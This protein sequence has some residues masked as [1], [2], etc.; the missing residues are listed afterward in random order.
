MSSNR[1]MVFLRAITV[2]SALG[3]ASMPQ[4]AGAQAASATTTTTTTTTTSDQDTA[5]QPLVLNPFIVDSSEDKGSYTANSTLA[6]TRVRTELKDVASAISVVTAQFLQD[7]GAKNQ[8][9]FLIYTPSTEV[10]GLRGNFSGVAGTAISEENTV[11]STTRVRG[12]DSADNTRDYFI[13]DI[14]WDAFDVGRVDLQRG[15]NSILFGTGSPAGIINV[16]TSG[17][18]FTNAYNVTNRIDEYGSLRDSISLN[19]ELIPGVLA[20]HLSALKDDEKYEQVPAFSNT[21]RYYGAFRFDPKLFG[22][23]SHTSIRGDFETGKQTSD[24]P[25]IIP[26]TDEITPWFTTSITTGGVTNPG[27]NKTT[28]NEYGGNTTNNPTGMSLPPGAFEQ[29]FGGQGREGWADVTNYYEATPTNRNSISNPTSPNGTP[30][31]ATASE[32][33]YGLVAANVPIGQEGAYLNQGTFAN[34]AIMPFS[35]YAGFAGT[36]SP[37]GSDSVPPNY[38]Y[39]NSPIPGG[40]Y[41]T[42]KYLQDPSIFNFYKLLLDGPN[43][44]EWKRWTAFNLTVDQTFFD[45]R[46]GFEV[47]YDQQKY[48]EGSVPFLQGQE[49]G[50]TVNVNET[51]P[52]GQANP[53]VGRPEVASGTGEEI[54]YQRTTTRQTFRATPTAELRSTDFFSSPTLTWLLGKSDVTGLYEKTTVVTFNYDYASY[55]LSPQWDAD[56]WLA[57]NGG[58]QADAL[59]SWNQFDFVALIGPSLSN[60]SSASGAHLNNINYIISPPAQEVVQ[61]FNSTWNKPTNPGSPGYVDPAAPYTFTNNAL[62]TGG[63]TGNVTVT[64]QSENPANYVGWEQHQVYYYSANDPSQF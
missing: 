63:G 3:F 48:T 56:N 36:I 52:N 11:D 55:A 20:I 32:Q 24:N 15:P 58:W 18:S 8:E 47:A 31:Y 37:T 22:K 46:I 33:N 59:G 30:I 9:D 42:D 53:N 38:A 64:T 49:Y 25:R 41:Y 57:Q 23:G 44:S 10:T 16:S 4:I 1:S 51:Y 45:D 40:G 28:V 29:I 43:K 2:T 39:P 27:L 12:L 13:S 26:P 54:D 62:G 5:S 17:A 6:G 21:T 60:A 7:T 14:P 34:Y 61:N 19:Q 50:I 35:S